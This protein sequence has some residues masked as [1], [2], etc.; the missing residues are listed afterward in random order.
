[1]P[2]RLRSRASSSVKKLSAFSLR[3]LSS[4]SV[5]SNPV[6]ITPPSFKVAGTSSL[7]ASLRRVRSRSKPSRQSQIPFSRLSVTLLHTLCNSGRRRRL[8]RRPS[9]SRGLALPIEMRARIRSMSAMPVS[10]SVST[11]CR[12][13]SAI[14]ISIAL[15]RAFSALW[16]RSG[17]LSQR[18]SSRLPMLVQVL[19]SMALRVAPGCPLMLESSSRL[20]LVAASSVTASLC[21]SVVIPSKCGGVPRCVSRTY[22]S[23]QPAAPVA[24]FKSSQ[25]KPCRSLVPNCSHNCSFAVVVSKCH[26]GLSRTV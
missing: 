8:L 18:D 19:S 1:M 5:L 24:S 10:C 9:R 11:S 12:A 3:F 20:R 14:K 21:A 17:R 15:K 7:S 23:T 2:V 16:L 25:P 26:G 13:A 22:C 6:L 4:S